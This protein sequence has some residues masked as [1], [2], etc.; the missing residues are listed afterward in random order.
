MTK[1]EYHQKRSE[2]I[3]SHHRNLFLLDTEYAHSNNTV[4]VGDVVTSF[5]CSI[6]VAS[7]HIYRSALGDPHCRYDGCMVTKKGKPF[8]IM[9]IGSVWQDTLQFVN[10]E[11]YIHG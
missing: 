5:A 10:G 4:I 11:P 7:V 2:A 1:E 9:K 6:R 3:R 8:K